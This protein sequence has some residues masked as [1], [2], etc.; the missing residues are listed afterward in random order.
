[1]INFETCAS[2]NV[3]SYYNNSIILWYIF[4]YVIAVDLVNRQQM[5]AMHN[6]IACRELGSKG[7]SPWQNMEI[8]W[9]KPHK[10]LRNY[11]YLFCCCL[12]PIVLSVHRS[13]FPTSKTFKILSYTCGTVVSEGV[14]ELHKQLY[15]SARHSIFDCSTIPTQLD[16]NP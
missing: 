10:N 13:F 6:V 14:M 16:G 7:S 3:W 12:G 2:L 4:C 5:H 1:M 15:Y 9:K 8:Q 11:T